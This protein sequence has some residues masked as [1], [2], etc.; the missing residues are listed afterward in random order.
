MSEN[1]TV[2]QFRTKHFRVAL[3]VCPEYDPPEDFLEFPEDLEF[4]R[5]GGWHWFCAR[6]TVECDGILLAE[7][8][9]GACSYH[10]L[11]DF[12]AGGYFR[13]MVREVIAEARKALRAINHIPLRQ[14]IE[15]PVS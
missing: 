14:R 11:A 12:K 10:G 9:L 5:E 1:E 3:E 2:W 13:D 15:E 8:Y 6:V 7:H 4:A